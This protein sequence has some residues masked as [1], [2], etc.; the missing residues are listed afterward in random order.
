MIE[1]VRLKPPTI[2]ADDRGYLLELVKEGEPLLDG[3]QVRQ[4]VHTMSY[5]GIIKAFHW[6]RRQWDIWYF[7]SGNARVVLYDLREG[8]PTKG[9]TQTFYLGEVNRT[10]I[11]IP[12]GVAHGYQVLGN[13]PVHLIYHVTEPYNPADPD[14]ERI[15]YDDPGIGYDWSIKFR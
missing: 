13:Q 1:G 10:L 6:H 8:S 7:V 3:I 15:P 9:E 12:P 14:E 2:H 5:P 11:A 4:T